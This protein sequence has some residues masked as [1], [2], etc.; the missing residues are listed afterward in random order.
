MDVKLSAPW[1]TYVNELKAMF[2]RDPEIT[3][4]YDEAENEVKLYVA[5]NVSK[6]DALSK[7]LP[8][9]KTFGNVTLKIA[10]IPP[11]VNEDEDI[12]LTFEKAFKDNPAFEYAFAAKTPIGDYRYIVFANKVVQFFNDQ[13]DDINGNKTTLYQEI[14]K[15]IFKDR[16]GVSYCTEASNEMTQ[17]LLGEWP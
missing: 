17:K 15:E 9:E 10:V 8:E 13:M 4:M 7:L 6:A 3:V 5:A 11:N 14:A 2:K 1:V 16:L 12:L